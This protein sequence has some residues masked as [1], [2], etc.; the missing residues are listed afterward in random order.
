LTPAEELRNASAP[1]HLGERG[2]G[3]DSL[4]EWATVHPWLDSAHRPQERSWHCFGQRVLSIAARQARLEVR[5]GIHG[6][7]DEQ[8]VL[9]LIDD[10]AQLSD[11]EVLLIEEAASEAIFR[12]VRG[13]RRRPDEHWMQSVIRSDPGLVGVEQPALRE[14][15]AFRAAD[16]PGQW[17]RGFVDIV[18]LDG[19]GDIAIVETKLA[20]N[21]DDL[22]AFQGL[23]YFIWAKAYLAGLQERLGAPV[24]ANPTLHYVLGESEDGARRM[25]PRSEVVARSLDLDAEVSVLRD[26]FNPPS[27]QPVLEPY[28]IDQ[29]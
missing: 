22:F 19:H 8:P 28:E 1:L 5:A 27:I 12:R 29:E 13:D 21:P 7:G 26:W 3:V 24:N 4:V 15:P 18:G 6:T 11:D 25:T 10:G 14:V 20:G 23:D 2:A 9:V 17:G 16:R